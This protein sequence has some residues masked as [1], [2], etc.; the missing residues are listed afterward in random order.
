MDYRS[1]MLKQLHHCQRRILYVMKIYF[2][3]NAEIDIF[4]D[5]PNTENPLPTDVDY[6]N[7][8]RSSFGRRNKK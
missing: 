3:K 5:K 4:S 6:N 1:K 8:K 7:V 2:T